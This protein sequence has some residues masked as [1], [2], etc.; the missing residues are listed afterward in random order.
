[1]QK[2]FPG[3]VF[4]YANLSNEAYGIINSIP[5]VMGFLGGKNSPQKVSEAKMKDIFALVSVDSVENNKTQIFEIGQTLNIIE[6]PFESFSGK[7]SLLISL[8]VTTTA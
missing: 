3:Y 6:G 1:M 5:K 8:I 7:F 2:L 4:V